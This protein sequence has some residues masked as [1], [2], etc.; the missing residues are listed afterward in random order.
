[1]FSK[2]I[3]R[4]QLT[5]SPNQTHTSLDSSVF[6]GVQLVTCRGAHYYVIS[7]YTLL[8]SELHHVQSG[9]FNW[10]HL[11]SPHQSD[12]GIVV[13][14][15]LSRMAFKQ[16]CVPLTITLLVVFTIFIFQDLIGDDFQL[17]FHSLSGLPVFF[18][19]LVKRWTIIEIP[20]H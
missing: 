8:E 7:D 10:A 18:L 13:N 11:W 6:L 3:T 15:G 5:Y 20:I 16:T 19:P 14:V 2:I 12:S 4:R 17:A 9:P 1:M